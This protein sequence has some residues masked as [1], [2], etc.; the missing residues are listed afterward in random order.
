[1]VD[2]ELLKSIVKTE[3]T[4]DDDGYVVSI[5]E[6]IKLTYADSYLKD[7]DYDDGEYEEVMS[8]LEKAVKVT[9][10]VNL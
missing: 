4:V 1:M 7:R 8:L 10:E 6:Y 2:M 3:V 9:I 5:K